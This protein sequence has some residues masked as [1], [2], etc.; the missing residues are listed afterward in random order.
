[1]GRIQGA[2]AM[3]TASLI[4]KVSKG[5]LRKLRNRP[6]PDHKLVEGLIPEHT[7]QCSVSKP[8][9]AQNV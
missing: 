8:H 2:L 9:R 3:S 7:L 6:R 5:K 1:M 4:P